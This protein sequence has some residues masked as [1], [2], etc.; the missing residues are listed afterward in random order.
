MKWI[1]G[2]FSHETNTFSTIPTD[3]AA[4][5]ARSWG[6]GDEIREKLAGTRTAIGGFLDVI[7]G[8]GD[9]AV[10]TVAASATP[11]GKVTV[12]AFDTITGYLVDGVK[13]NPDADGILLSLHGAMVPEH[14]D[15][16]E[17]ETLTRVREA[18]G[19]A[20]PIVVVLDL[21]SHITETM[22]EKATA[23]IGFQKYPHT[24]PVDRG[25]DAAKL[26]AKVAEGT[27]RPVA[28]LEKPPLIPV[29]GTCN[30]EFGFYVDL[31]AEALRPDRSEKILASSLF[32]GFSYAD[33]PHMGYAVLVYADGDEA[34]AREEAKR[35]ANSAW[36]G[37]EAFRYKPTSI[38]DAVTRA[39]EAPEKPLVINEMADNPGGG[40]SNDSVAV[41]RELIA[42]GVTSAAVGTIYDPQ[43]VEACEKIGVGNTIKA[44][45]GAKS[46]DMHGEPIEI[47]GRVRLIYD[48]HFTYKGPMSQGAPGSIGKAAVIDVNGIQ[49]IA[50][51]HRAQTLDPEVFR[52]AGIEPND[53]DI[54][55][56]KSAVHFRAGFA[57]VAKE[58]ITADG[59][60]LT[61]L[62]LSIFP[63][64]NIRRPLWPIDDD[65]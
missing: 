20:I 50:C 43:V 6:V 39:I 56:V 53:V 23:I 11:S 64:S 61:S 14:T 42:Q 3:L 29:C 16:G 36:E 51:S 7:D 44:T 2:G 24:D 48:G 65:A 37:R 60:G 17:G 40:G 21:H 41:L 15:D 10:L 46:D 4:F 13:A 28:A 30:T 1:V 26:I 58:I 38:A 45:L 12:D 57:P 31:W 32:A 63:W 22:V 62:D 35:L 55:L 19:D 25:V 49:V 54:V 5:K 18:A 9:E 34:V 8:R 33:I 59:P 47:E 52:S 27:A